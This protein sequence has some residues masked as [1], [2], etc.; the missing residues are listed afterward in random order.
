VTPGSGASGPSAALQGATALAL[1]IAGGLVVKGVA[2]LFVV[3][4]AGYD[5]RLLWTATHYYLRGANPFEA[6]FYFYDLRHGL[7][8]AN[9]PAYWPDLG[10]PIEV[11]YPPSS[12]LT[13]ILV[14][15][16][17][18]WMERGYYAVLSL[19]SCGFIARWASAS[20]RTT[21]G[22]WLLVG[23][24]LANLGY[25]QTILNGNQGILVIAGLVLAISLRMKRPIVAGLCLGVALV[26]PTISAPFILLFLVDR[27]Y[28]TLAVAAL[29]LLTST[30]LTAAL[31]HASVV[32]LFAQSLEGS[33]RYVIGGYALWKVFRAWGMSLGI[34]LAVNA[35]VFFIPLMVLLWRTRGRSTFTP[36]MLAL[37]AVVARVSTY[38]NSIDNVVMS[39]LAVALGVRFLET[40]RQVDAWW[41]VAIVGSLLIPFVYTDSVLGHTLLYVLWASAAIRE[42]ARLLANPSSADLA[43]HPGGATNRL[44]MG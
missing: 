20:R 2:Q 5:L 42:V 38:H 43:I 16:L 44:M 3:H 31:S 17:P 15:G 4:N 33:S 26:K 8:P 35:A 39:F 1:L 34:A 19:A 37:V 7:T 22:A 27:Q 23:V 25:S 30:L 13:Q 40:R 28:L 29:Y 14:Y 12:T 21:S 10:W 6:S 36:S 41:L 11:N 24:A 32:T 9:V 18:G